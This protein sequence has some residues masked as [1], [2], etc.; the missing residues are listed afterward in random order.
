M[1]MHRMGL[2]GQDRGLGW[3]TQI[4]LETNGLI[5]VLCALTF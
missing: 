3:G 1:Y 5:W 4:G 2:H